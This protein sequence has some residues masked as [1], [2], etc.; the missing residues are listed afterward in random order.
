MS[1][2]MTVHVEA[3]SCMPAEASMAQILS[4]EH[5]YLPPYLMELPTYLYIIYM[6]SIAYPRLSIRPN[7]FI[8]PE[9]YDNAFLHFLS[10]FGR[11][12]A[13]PIEPSSGLLGAMQRLRVPL[14][15]PQ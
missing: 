10:L 3:L 13:S 7:Q 4:S 8:S 12:G 15:L 6:K 9:T 11:W 5:M 14:E 1:A 2:I